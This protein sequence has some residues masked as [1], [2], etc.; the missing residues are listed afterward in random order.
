MELIKLPIPDTVGA[1]PLETCIAKRRSIRRYKDEPLTRVQLS[2]LLWAGQG[3]TDPKRGYRAVPSAGAT[4]PAE[5]Y[6]VF[7][8]GVYHYLPREHSLEPHLDGDIRP[9]LCKACLGQGFVRQAPLSVVIG[10]IPSRTTGHYGARGHAYVGY[11]AGHI[12]QNLHL[13]AIALGLDSVAVGAY[14]DNAVAEAVHLPKDTD[15]VYIVCIGK[16]G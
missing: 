4:F 14:N 1:V 2:Q 16:A 5:L 15:P 9:A 10:M 7:H 6:T 3:M 12:A 8:E 11:E 13:Q